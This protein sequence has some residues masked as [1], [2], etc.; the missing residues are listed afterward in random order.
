MPNGCG[1]TFYI[2]ATVTNRTNTQSALQTQQANFINLNGSYNATSKAK[3]LVG[4]CS[5]NF[6]LGRLVGTAYVRSRKVNPSYS[7]T[8]G[9]GWT[10]YNFPLV[11]FRP[12]RGARLWALA[13]VV[14]VLVYCKMTT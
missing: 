1:L 10:T 14:W 8:R 7:A 13:S 9:N 11:R 3:C 12:G 4:G 6:N 2:D 5:V